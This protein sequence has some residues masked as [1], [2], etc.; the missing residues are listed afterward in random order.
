VRFLVEL[1][2]HEGSQAAFEAIAREMVA[3]S[4]QESGT[5]GYEWFVS[6][7]RRRCRLIETYANSNAVLT[8]LKGPVV[9]QLVP[10][11]LEQSKLDRFQVCG[12][13][14]PEAA[15]MLTG[16]GAE[17]FSNWWGFSR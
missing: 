9:G 17:I 10:K 13:P 7:D 12:D 3:G 15:A 4:E 5:L 16:F 2:I 1:T 11:L 8:H 6:N 14:G